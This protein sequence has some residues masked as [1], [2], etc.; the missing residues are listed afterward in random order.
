MKYLIAFILSLSM[1]HA[2][3]TVVPVEVGDNP[4]FSGKLS[5]SLETKRGNTDKDEYNAGLRLQY[6]NNESYVLWSDIIGSYGEVD[7]VKNTNKTYA[8]VRYIH[9]LYKENYTWETFFQ[10][11]TNEFTKVDRKR[12]YGGGVRYNTSHTEYGEIFLGFGGF[13]E[14]IE[15]TTFIDPHENNVRINSYLAYTKELGDKSKV[16]YVAYYQPNTKD[17]TDHIISNAIELYI[18]IYEKFY[19]SFVFYY[20]IDSKPAIGVEKEDITQKTSFIYEF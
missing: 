12:L 20:D 4:G 8:H 16:A 19:L 2:I 3:I 7:G 6:D 14:T 11:A 9:D 13:Y 5:G 17:F 15:Y 1:A 10:S 18:N